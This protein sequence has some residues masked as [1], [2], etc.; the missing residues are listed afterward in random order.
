MRSESVCYE[1]ASSERV[2]KK[3]QAV[4]KG[5]GHGVQ[6]QVFRRLKKK[7]R[8]GG[9]RGEGKWVKESPKYNAIEKKKTSL[10]CGVAG[11][12]AHVLYV[13]GGLLA[14]FCLGPGLGALKN[15][16]RRAPCIFFGVVRY[17]I[18]FG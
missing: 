8:G 6:K 7:G 13:R 10:N 15:C 11:T 2:K 14:C 17:E 3:S 9:K 1:C 16:P 4:R 5:K 18:L 12:A